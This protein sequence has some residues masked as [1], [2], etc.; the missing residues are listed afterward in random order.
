MRLYDR[1]EW[2]KVRETIQKP[3]EALAY[4]DLGERYHYLLG[5]KKSG[6]YRSGRV[7]GKQ[8]MFDWLYGPV[9]EELF[10][11]A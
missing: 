9:P 2:F 10:K 8:E 6:G 7:V 5:Q 11:G 4:A 1:I 3:Q